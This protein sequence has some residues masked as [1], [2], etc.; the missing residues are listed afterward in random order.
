MKNWIQRLPLVSVTPFT[1]Q[2]FPGRSACI[3]WFAGC[4]MRCPYCH[5]PDFVLG[6][7]ERMDWENTLRFLRNR[8]RFLEGVTLSGGECL[9]S[10]AVEP[11]IEEIKQLGFQVKVD[12]NG[13][14]PERLQLLLERGWIDYVALDFK[15]PLDDYERVTGWDCSEL[16]ERS[17][18]ALRS[19][20]VSFELRTTVHPEIVDEACVDRMFDYLNT[21]GYTGTLYLQHFQN[22]P[23]TIG[24]H[25]AA[26]RRFRLSDLNREVGFELRFRNFTAHEVRAFEALQPV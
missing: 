5:N 14:S 10:S 15:A 2:D 9:L 7:C 16:W 24:S 22:A 19:S 21:Q 25:G 8:R 26:K 20:G 4:Q 1:L 18:A 11:M 23:K 17:F 12:T 6:K 13:G 3:L